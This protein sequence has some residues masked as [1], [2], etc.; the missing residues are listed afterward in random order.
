MRLVADLV[1]TPPAELMYNALKERL[2]HSHQLTDI[3]KVDLLVDMPSLGDRKPTQLLAAMVEACPRGQENSV[4]MSALFL[5][6]LPADVRIL[7]AHMDHTRLKE[8]ATAAD[9]LVAMREVAAVAARG[10]GAGAVKKAAAAAKQ[11]KKKP[12]DE[13]EPSKAARQAAGLC[14]RHWRY[15]AQAFSCDGDCCWPGNGRAGGN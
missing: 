15:G 13:P 11:K 4:F 8:M 7:L 9:Q 5:R 6:K 12:L 14:L 3:Q 1:E 10:G 2:L